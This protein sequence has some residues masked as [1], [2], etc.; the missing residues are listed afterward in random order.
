MR[1]ILVGPPG[2]GKGTQA[3]RLVGTYHIRHISSGDMLRAAV[4]EGTP[5]GQ[6]ADRYMKAGKLVPDDVVIGMILERIKKADCT[7]GFMLDGF[8]R[9]LPQAEALDRALLE[10]GFELDMVVVIEVPDQLLEE[11]AVGRRSD[12]Q[13]G[14]IYHLKYNPPPPEIAARLVHRK[15]DT[16][17][18][19]T[20][21]IQKYHAETSPILP[22]YDAKGILR[23]VDGVG[24]PDAITMRLRAA[25]ES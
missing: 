22:F 19:V 4:Q 7:A 15:D 6:E 21:R 16:V 13:T 11:R 17:E 23:R 1:I 2:A 5:L 10:A 18:A 20:T 12:P 25:L 8:P 3:A 9:T 24:D 14:A